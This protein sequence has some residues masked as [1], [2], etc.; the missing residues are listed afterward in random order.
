[1]SLLKGATVNVDHE[2]AVGNAIGSVFDVFWQNAYTTAEGKKIPAGINAVLKIDGKSN[3]RLARGIMMDPPSIHSN[4]VTVQFEW[5]KS[6]PKMEDDE[7]REKLG[8]L[9]DRGELVRRIATNIA[10]YYETSLVSAG[11]DPYAQKIGTNGKILNPLWADT[12]ANLKESIPKNIYV[13]DWKTYT[14]QVSLSEETEITENLKNDNMLDLKSL[15]A[16]LGFTPTD[17]INTEEE[18][19]TAVLGLKTQVSTIEGLNAKITDLT[20]KNGDLTTQLTDKTTELATKVTE[21]GKFSK[22]GPLG[23]K[24]LS[25]LRLSVINQYKAINGDKADTTQ[26]ENLEKMSDV[27]TLEA[28]KKTYDED[29]DKKCPLQCKCGSHDISR[30][31]S[32]S[33]QKVETGDIKSNKEVK[34]S[35]T[36]D[37]KTSSYIFS[38]PKEKK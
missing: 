15:I 21:L 3:P 26:I 14:D 32:V 10:M 22:T 4:S 24:Y 16:L 35:L 23:E 8:R 2:M 12:R 11:Q 31:S 30:K 37:F 13:Y 9:D 34:D 20:T 29:F 1:M 17:N 18:L 38:D 33:Q 7:F 28:L 25:D 19:K 36:K 6:H 27:P 5:E